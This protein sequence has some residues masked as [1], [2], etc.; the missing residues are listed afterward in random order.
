MRNSGDAS[1]AGPAH[2][3]LQLTACS[4][5]SYHLERPYCLSAKPEHSC[6]RLWLKWPELKHSSSTSG[7]VQLLPAHN[8]R[9]PHNRSQDGRL[10][11][12]RVGKRRVG[13]PRATTAALLRVPSDAAGTWLSSVRRLRT[14]Q[15]AI[16]PLDAAPQHAVRILP[17]QVSGAR[18]QSE[19]G[20]AESADPL[21]TDRKSVV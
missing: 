17:A 12:P 1:A 3:A 13:G 15:H 10:L 21:P 14:N 4:A 16:R 5:S 19:S 8:S 20:A 9:T 2:A 18:V 11:S 6:T 7:C